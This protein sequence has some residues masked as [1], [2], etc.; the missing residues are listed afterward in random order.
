MLTLYYV[1]ATFLQSWRISKICQKI[2]EQLASQASIAFYALPTSSDDGFDA[3]MATSELCANRQVAKVSEILWLH[4]NNRGC[5]VMPLQTLLT[6]PWISFP[7]APGLQPFAFN[8]PSET[9]LRSLSLDKLGLIRLLIET[10]IQPSSDDVQ[11]QDIVRIEN[12]GKLIAWKIDSHL[13]VLIETDIEHFTKLLIDTF[14]QNHFLI[15]DQL[16]LLRIESVKNDGAPQP[17]D[18]LSSHLRKPAR[19]NES[20]KDDE[21]SKHLEDLRAVSVLANQATEYVYNKN[22]TEGK[23]GAIKPDLIPQEKRV[24]ATTESKKSKESPKKINE[25]PKKLQ[26]DAKKSDNLEHLTKELSTK[27][28]PEKSRIN[29]DTDKFIKTEQLAKTADKD[30]NTTATTSTKDNAN[31]SSPK[32][33]QSPSKSRAKPT[34]IRKPAVIDTGRFKTVKFSNESSTSSAAVETQQEASELEKIAAAKLAEKTKSTFPATVETEKPESNASKVKEPAATIASTT[35][36]MLKTEQTTIKPTLITAKPELTTAAAASSGSSTSAVK[37]NAKRPSLKRHKDSLTECKPLNVLVYAETSTAKES[38]V[39]TLKEILADNTYTIY[40]L[41]AQQVEQKHWLNTTA[42]L[43]V[44]GTVPNTIGELFVDY[45]LRGGKVL[46]LCSDILHFILPTYRTAEVREHELVQFSYDKWQKVK[47]MHHI[48]CYQPSPVKKNFSTDSDDSAY[49]NSRKPALVC[50]PRSIELKDLKG[51]MHQL[52]VKVLGTEETWNTPSLL[53]ASN[54]K[55]GGT[56]V[57]SQ[58]HLEIN[59]T[60]FETDESKYSILKQND[61]IRHEIFADLLKNHLTLSVQGKTTTENGAGPKLIFKNAYF[62]GRHEAKFELLE[63]LKSSVDADNILTTPKL[64]MKFCGPDDK[65][66]KVNS[67][68]LPI[69]IHSCPEDFSTVDYFEN[70][71]TA[72]VGRLVIYAPIVNSSQHVISDLELTNGI[73]VIPR[74]QTDG[75]GRSNNQWLSPLGCAMFSI[76]LHINL[77]TPLGQRLPLIQHILGVAMINSLK[78]H[79][80]Y[81]VLNLG[82]KWPN[83]AYANGINKIGGLVVKTTLMGTNAIVNIGCAINLDNRKPTICLNDMIRDY[84]SANQQKLPS[85]KYEMLLALMFNEIE[86]LIELVQTGEFETFYQL[87]YDLWLH[88]NQSITICDKDGA[89]K[90]AKVIGIDEYGYLKVQLTNGAVEVVQPDGNSF[91]MLKG[92]IIPK[93]Y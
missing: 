86:R 42:L 39:N 73:V 11:Q 45:F 69:L 67:N 83:D 65:L 31:N 16:P 3:S 51:V 50:P 41:T 22:K 56:A 58:V 27:A 12:Y 57:F 85:I 29:K 35:Q 91:D 80:L 46:S 30:A 6:T 19:S 15:N 61:N 43:V 48:F 33:H 59:P 66:P 28:S 53:L 23:T 82:L 7:E 89:K 74:Q 62:L 21:W 92:L 76:Q 1:S 36:E 81:K 2:T 52:D 70:L 54:K 26:V 47:M 13:A 60:E 10:D 63:K 71:K 88:S 14:L 90:E 17:Y 18:K 79:P 49:T 24:S 64:T 9:L 5:C 55:S 25:S 72:Y 38:A 44:C 20:L 4:G 8:E 32:S 75:M 37:D 34:E 68:I 87:Y 77:D 93:F 78:N 84:N 40:P